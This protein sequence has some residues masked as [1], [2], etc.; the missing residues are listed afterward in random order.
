MN[1]WLETLTGLMRENLWFAPVLSLVAGVVTS[2]TPGSLSA[3]PM[4]LAYVGAASDSKRKA[5][6]LSLTMALGMAVTFAVFGSVASAIG[7]VMHGMGHWWHVLLGVL[8]VVMALQ[9]WG[10]IH[11]LPEH[12]HGDDCKDHDHC[13]CHSPRKLIRGTGYKGAFL[14][15]ALGGVFASHCATPVML[16]L[17]AMVVESG[18]GIWWG[19]FL[20]ILYALGHS[21]LL[22]VAGTSYGAVEDLMNRPSSQKVGKVL[23][24]VVG[25]LIFAIGLGMFFVE[26]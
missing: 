23:K 12:E 18:H 3:V 4:I 6:R 20:M 17:L 16:A 22:V 13:E 2:F 8:M 7:H 19:I 26:N 9:I 1:V 15:G 24:V 14:T 11:L 5:L 25:L 10:V 21:I